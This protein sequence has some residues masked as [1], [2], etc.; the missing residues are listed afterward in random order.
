MFETGTNVVAE[1]R[2][3]AAEGREAADASTSTPAAGSRD[4]PPGDEAGGRPFDEYVSDPAKPVPY[5]DKI[6]IGMASEYM[7]ADQ[8]FAAPPAGRARLPDA[9]CWRRT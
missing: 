8:R 6:G 1:V 4:E 2:R 5:I 9:T 7:T 3:L